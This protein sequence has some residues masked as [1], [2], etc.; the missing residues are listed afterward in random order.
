MS[1]QCRYGGAVL[2]FVQHLHSL[3]NTSS[4]FSL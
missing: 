1:K 4:H 3:E 2:D